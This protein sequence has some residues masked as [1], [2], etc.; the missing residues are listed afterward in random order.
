MTTFPELLMAA[1]IPGVEIFSWKS[2]CVVIFTCW[3]QIS[4][5]LLNLRDRVWSFLKCLVWDCLVSKRG[6][7]LELPFGHDSPELSIPDYVFSH[8]YDMKNIMVKSKSAPQI[9]VNVPFFVVR[10][11]NFGPKSPLLC[12]FYL[13]EVILI[14]FMQLVRYKSR[15]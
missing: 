13:W 4:G 10:F 8:Y 15:L 3:I 1:T 12:Y 11:W 9:A 14:L 7:R 6:I 2:A 5:V